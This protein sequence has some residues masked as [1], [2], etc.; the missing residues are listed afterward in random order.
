M[1]SP[2]H[3]LYIDGALI[4]VR[5]LVN[6]RQ[7][8]RLTR[9]TVTYWHV[10][11]DRHDVVLAEGLPVESYLDT[12]DRANFANGG[13]VVA[14]HPD[15]AS[16]IWEAAGCAPAAGDRPEACGRCAGGWISRPRAGPRS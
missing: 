4:P 5:Y 15:F 7:I 12:G 9:K 8:R 2:D 3:A 16:R 13:R 6:G 14:L 11:L 1:L 10:E